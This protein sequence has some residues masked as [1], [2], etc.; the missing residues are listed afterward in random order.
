[1]PASSY[2]LCFVVLLACCAMAGAAPPPTPP[3]GHPRVML[4]PAD[5]PRV[6]ARFH[7]PLMAETKTRLLREANAATDGRLPDGKPESS[8]AD[9]SPRVCMQAKAFLY[10]IDGDETMG[11]QAV[12][13]VLDYLSS[14]TTTDEEGGYHVSALMHESILAAALV[15]DW[16]YPL[17]SAEQKLELIRQIERVSAA[18]EYGWPPPE[19]VGFVTGHYSELKPTAMLAA[20]IAV[21]DEK[22]E[23]YDLMADHLWNGFAPARNFFYPG[24]KHHQGSAYGFSR[25]LDEVISSFL[26]TRMGVPN[27]CVSDQ[28]KLPYWFVY[29]HTP[30]GLTFVEGDDY[31]RGSGPGWRRD[32]GMWLML[33]GMERDPYVQDLALRSRPLRVPA[34]LRVLAQDET[35]EAKPLEELPLTRYF[36]S[37][38]GQMIARTGWDLDGGPGAPAAVAMFHVKEWMFGN[39]DHLDAG[40]FSFYYKGSLTMDSGIYEGPD[41]GYGSEHFKNYFQ[42]SVAHNTLLVL[43]PDEPTPPY[44]GRNLESRDGGQFWPSTRAE[45]RRIDDI[46]ALRPRAEILAHEFGPD[47]IAPD[48]TYLAGDLARCYQALPPYPPKVSEV[49]RSF[50]FLNLKDDQHP[51]AL[52]VFDRVTAAKPEFRKSWL[53]HSINE[54]DVEGSATTIARTEDG[55][56]GRL[57]NHTLLPAADNCEIVK[58]GGPGREFWVDGRNYPFRAHDR[59]NNEPGAWRVEVSPRAPAEADLFLNVMQVMDAVGGPEPLAPELIETSALVGARIA[60]RVVLF[61]KSKRRLNRSLSFTVGG[62]NADLGILVTDLAPGRWEVKGPVTLDLKATDEGGALYFRGPAGDYRLTFAG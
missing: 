14:I 17:F 7:S 32:G 6:R 31:Y 18:A 33:A 46:I 38:F 39:H 51:A 25:F 34:I 16:C 35:L 30:D 54:P 58:V 44:W 21:Y 62:A 45:Y 37:P 3:D 43:D 48:Y 19:D 10:L 4:R 50:V 27:P 41:G 53:L 55:Y 20:G 8:W 13:M 60:D 36:G 12:D 52:I 9:S 5:I 57:V 26:V 42:R 49:K 47:P 24:G 22:P 29:A 11:R 40:H 1:M 61:G 56:N 23:I 2:V 59:G 15:Y 28:A